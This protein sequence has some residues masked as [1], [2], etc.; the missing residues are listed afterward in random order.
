MTF[1]RKSVKNYKKVVKNLC[2]KGKRVRRIGTE[3][4]GVTLL[5]FVLELWRERIRAVPACIRALCT[6]Q[7]VYVPIGLHTLLGTFL[8]EFAVCG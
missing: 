3:I 6:V 1:V 4:R 7:Y 2:G 5:H 8:A